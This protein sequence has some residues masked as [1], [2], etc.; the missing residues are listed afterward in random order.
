MQNAVGSLKDVKRTNV[1][2][3]DLSLDPGITGGTE[4]SGYYNINTDQP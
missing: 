2:V 1:K 3:M 4:K